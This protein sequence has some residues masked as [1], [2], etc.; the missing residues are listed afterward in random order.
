MNSHKGL[1][2]ITLDGIELDLKYRALALQAVTR[3]TGQNPPEY[4]A[5]L[6]GLS[7]DSPESALCAFDL[8]F[9]MT[10][11][12]AGL[13][14]HPKFGRQKPEILNTKILTLVENEADKRNVPLW[15]IP[16]AILAEIL[17]AVA[18]GMGFARATEAA[19]DEKKDP[20]PEGEKDVNGAGE[21]SDG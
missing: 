16:S 20:A 19:E 11:L 21:S 4:L 15:E 8:D 13:A 12:M 9:V 7:A 6:A 10:L 5:R 1:V 2:T 17:P 18:G 14:A 3:L